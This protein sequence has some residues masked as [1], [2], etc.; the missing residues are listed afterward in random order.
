MATVLYD[1]I[2]TPLVYIVELAFSILYRVLN[3]PGLALIGVSLVVNFLCLPLYRMADLA[4]EAERDKQKS[5]EKWVNHIKK[6]FKGDEQ[7]MKLTAYYRQQNYKPISALNGSVSLLLQ[8]PIFMAAYNYLSNLEMLKGQSFLFLSDLG[9]PDQMFTI[10]GFAV[11]VMPIAMT[12]LN[13]VSTFIYTRD[14]ALR[15]KI[16]AYGLA[17]VFLV[18]LYRS[19]SG[20]VLYW[21]CNQIFSLAKNLF[22]KVL[23]HPNEV[24]CVIGQL[25]LL[26]FGGYMVLTNRMNS[27]RRVVTFTLLAVVI[28]FF[29]ITPLVRNRKGIKQKKTDESAKTST[30]LLASILAA[31]LVGVLIPSALIADSPAEFIDVYNFVSPLTYIVHSGCVAAG[32]FILWVGTYYYLSDNAG[33]NAI[34]LALVVIAGIFV[35]DYFVFNDALGTITSDLVFET[36]PA[37]GRRAILANATAAVALAAA[38]FALWH[39]RRSLINPIVGILAVAVIGLSAPNISAIVDTTNEKKQEAEAIANSTELAMFDENGNPLPIFNLS[40][41]GRNVVIVFMDRAISGYLPYIFNENPSLVDRFNGF[42][43]YPNT[44]SYGPRTVFG[45]PALYGGYDYTFKGMNSRDD[46]S[47]QEKHMEALSIMPLLFTENGFD[48]TVLDPPLVDYQFGVSDYSSLA[49]L[50]PDATYVHACGAYTS[51]Y[52]SDGADSHEISRA[53]NFLFYGLFRAVPTGLRSMVYDDGTYFSTASSTY[54]EFNAGALEAHDLVNAEVSTAEPTFTIP[55]EFLNNYTTLATLSAI[56]G[57]EKGDNNNFVIMQNSTTHTPSLLQLPDYV[58]SIYLNNEGLEDYSRF[59][60][61]G[62]TVIMDNASQLAHYHSNMAT[63]LLLADWF[64]FMRAR[65]VYDNT[66]IIIVADH[67]YEL[68]QWEDLIYDDSL[69]IEMVNPLLMVKDFDATG[70]ATDDEFMTLGDTPVI[71]MNGLIQDPVN[72]YTGNPITSDEKNS[73]PQEIT[74]SVQWDVREYQTGNT[75]NTED[76]HTYSVHDSIF[77]F[78]NWKRLD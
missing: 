62:R 38:L 45:S 2:V 56:T 42:T 27:V 60:L 66:R 68:N 23:K 5:M 30:F 46:I 55:N 25:F 16:Q 1:F 65:G 72:P 8:I 14:L 64:D 24:L 53:R 47:L 22:F 61:N 28:E 71:A 57:I 41:E 21:T 75:F 67:G 6:H 35:L 11:N 15:D 52:L 7:Y 69:D 34:S 40:T 70:F 77:D 54:A 13:C 50:A 10:A 58:P 4:Q 43:Y 44:L 73:E 26:L 17:M 59:T 33:K 48:A 63:M 37:F 29:V 20:L 49:E 78:D 74:S 3:N 39:Y 51:L 19:P 36:V 31:T 18:L 9:A 12:L 76:G 32:F